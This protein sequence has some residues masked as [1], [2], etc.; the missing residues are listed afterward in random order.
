[1]GR[2]DSTLITQ[3]EL[4]QRGNEGQVIPK[5]KKKVARKKEGKSGNRGT[6]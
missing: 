1:M 5:I 3:E 6:L 2:I 4:G